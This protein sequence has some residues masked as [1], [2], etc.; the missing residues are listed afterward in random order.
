MKNIARFG[1]LSLCLIL[2]SI[3]GFSQRSSFFFNLDFYSPVE[4]N[5]NTGYGSGLGAT[6]MLNKN[7]VFSL[8][9]K[10][11][12]YSV[13]KVEDGF[14]NGSLTSTPILGSLQYYFMPD[15]SFSP[16]VTAASLF[17][18]RVLFSESA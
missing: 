13:D 15:S 1:V 3:P 14:L 9:F 2:I 16:Y 10:Y 7:I 8:E 6:F 5:I 11:G 17:T 18:S 12:R 4:E